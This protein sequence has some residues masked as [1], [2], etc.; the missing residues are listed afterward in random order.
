MQNNEWFVCIFKPSVDQ[1][2]QKILE[3]FICLNIGIG[4]YKNGAGV[5]SDVIFY[6]K[7]IC[8]QDTKG[9]KKP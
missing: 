3:V 4:Q 5:L 2:W 7:S 8:H 1:I 9:T 6:W